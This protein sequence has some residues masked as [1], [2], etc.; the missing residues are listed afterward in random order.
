M[1]YTKPALRERI[2]ARVLK[3]DKGGRP[4]QW[5]A[6]KAQLVAHEY[7]KA[8]GGYT[9]PRTPA[10]RSLSKW[11]SEKWGTMSGKPSIQGPHATGERYLPEKA[12]KA[13]SPK[14]Y[15]ATSA[16]KRRGIRMGKQYVPQPREIAKKTAR[17][18]M[19]PK[20]TVKRRTVKRRSVKASPR[21]RTV[22]ASPKKRS[23]RY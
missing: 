7:E 1:G 14:Q 13:L 15:R 2:K 11:S 16:A 22:K 4:G 10:Q 3:G 20:R 5:S 18:R 12:R 19:S 6:R 8:G 23:G 21:R 17:Y 9:G